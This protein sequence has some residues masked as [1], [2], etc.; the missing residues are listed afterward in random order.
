MEL[1]RKK[2]KDYRANLFTLQ[3]VTDKLLG[4]MRGH[5][6]SCRREITDGKGELQP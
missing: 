2:W 3:D 6:W 1:S 5:D 4:H